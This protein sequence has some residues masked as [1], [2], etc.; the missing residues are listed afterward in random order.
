[1]P[2]TPGINAR[3]EKI[4]V[5][6][7]CCLEP[8]SRGTAEMEDIIFGQQAMSMTSMMDSAGMGGQDC[9]EQKGKHR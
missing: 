3:M 9:S 4:Q 1:M 5:R 2:A 7:E 8:S 6:G